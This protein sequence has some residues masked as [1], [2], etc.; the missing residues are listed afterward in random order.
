M[1]LFPGEVRISTHS[2]L[3]LVS[4]LHICGAAH[5]SRLHVSSQR[6]SVKS[7]ESR[8]SSR[9]LNS[10]GFMLLGTQENG[11]NYGYLAKEAWEWGCR[12]S[13]NCGDSFKGKFH[14]TDVHLLCISMV[15]RLHDD[16]E[17]FS[18]KIKREE[19]HCTWKTT[20]KLL[21][22]QLCLNF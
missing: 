8:S 5:S 19:S 12:P 6:A 7:D 18:N 22:V 2:F 20:Q 14:H 17:I 11:R 9:T 15:N 10:F 21:Y 1:F 3:V 16:D 13:C 4:Y